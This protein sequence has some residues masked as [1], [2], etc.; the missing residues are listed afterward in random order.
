[1]H[2]K[3]PAFMPDLSSKPRDL[4]CPVGQYNFETRMALDEAQRIATAREP[5]SVFADIDSEGNKCH[6]KAIRVRGF[7]IGGKTWEREGT[8]SEIVS[9][10]THFGL[11]NLFATFVCY[12]GTHL[13]LA[14][15]RSTLIKRGIPGSKSPSISAVPL[16][17]LTLPSSPFTICGQ[18]F[19]LLPLEQNGSRWAW[20][21]NY[22]SLS[23][24]KKKPESAD[25][26]HIKNLQLTV[27]CQLIEPIPLD[28][29]S[30]VLIS[31]L[32]AQYD[33]TG[34]CFESE[35]EKTWVFSNDFLLS[36][37]YR[38]R[39]RIEKDSTL[40][41]KI[42]LFN[43]VH[44]GIYPY[45]AQPNPNEDYAGVIYAYSI[46]D[47]PIFEAITNRQSCRICSKT[48]KSSDIQNHVGQHI[49]KALRNIHDESAKYPVSAD[50]PCGTC[51]RS[52][53]D[54]LCQIRIKSKKLDSDCPSAYPF[55]IKAA[56]K[57]SKSRPCTN[58]PIQCPFNCDQIH[59]KYNFPQHLKE[60]HPSW[61]SL[62]SSEFIAQITITPE[63]EVGLGIP[64]TNAL[65]WPPLE[66]PHSPACGQKRTSSAAMSPRT[67]RRLY[68]KDV[69][70]RNKLPRL[71]FPLPISSSTSRVVPVV[72]SETDD[73]FQ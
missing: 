4:C 52:I 18:I 43:G 3:N 5:H 22:V 44:D 15:A 61:R 25:V 13:G 37:W 28:E 45:E 55:L 59:W 47:T 65:L 36:V 40:H 57:S 16:A 71:S 11:K 70:N 63:E 33:E 29:S 32:M 26:S 24:K 8:N 58:I 9:P 23:L 6:K 56:A 1:M 30:E 67:P 19:S 73:V 53:N 42:P 20:D 12:N 64:G 17:E 7:T 2:P 46:V 60:R 38:L 66:P 62:A 10:S 69:D 31:D 54:N 27:S 50:Y 41:D 34:I 48:V 49:R 39:E 68:C 21:G 51:G 35:R 72:Y 14:L